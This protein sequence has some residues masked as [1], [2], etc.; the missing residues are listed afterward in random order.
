MGLRDVLAGS[1]A[2]LEEKGIGERPLE[3]DGDRFLSMMQ[4]VRECSGD[5]EL[6]RMFMEWTDRCPEMQE[7]LAKSGL[8]WRGDAAKAPVTVTEKPKQGE[9]FGVPQGPETSEPPVWSGEDRI[10]TAQVLGSPRKCRVVGRAGP[11]LKVVTAEGPAAVSVV[12]EDCVAPD[13]L[14]YAK[15]RG[16]HLEALAEAH[17]AGRIGRALED[18]AGAQG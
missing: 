5:S 16:D 9:A 3:D 14:E 18:R 12:R 8:P 10:I 17:Y 2:A 1:I 7:Y 4:T 11:M 6:V 15:R 13:D